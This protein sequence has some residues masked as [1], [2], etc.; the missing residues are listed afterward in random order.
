MI[1]DTNIY[2]NR[3]SCYACGI[4]VE[5]CIMDNL[6]LFLAPCR[7]ECPLHMNCQGYVR[8][9]AHGKEIEAAKEMRAYLPFGGILG[10]VCHHPCEAVCERIQLGDGALHIRALKRYLADTFPEV[11]YFVPEIGKPTDKQIAIIGSGPAGLMAAYELRVW[12]HEVV[13]YESE[14][15]PGGLL[16]WGIPSF[17]LPISETDKAIKMLVNMDIDFRTGEKI[18]EKVPFEDLERRFDSILVAVG[19]GLSAKLNI[20]GE[21]SKGVYKGLELLKEVKAGKRPRV[22]EVVIVI[23]GGNVAVDTALTCLKLGAT[24][25]KMVCLEDKDEMPAFQMELDEALEE[26]VTLQ[27][28]RGPKE[29]IYQD[30]KIKVVLEECICVFDDTGNFCPT[31]NPNNCDTL[32]ADTVIVAIGQTGAIQGMPSSLC[33]DNCF[34]VDPLSFQS[35]KKQMIFVCGDARTGTS[36]VVEAMAEG[37]EAAISIDRFLRGEGLKW[38]RN[39]WNG[40][41]LREYEVDRSCGKEFPR[42]KLVK[43]PIEKRTFD[44]EVEKGLN[45]ESAKKEAERCLSCGRAV[46]FN[47]TCWSCLPCEIECPVNALE[48]RMPY[49]IR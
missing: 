5:R 22:G 33:A 16:R 44:K 35:Y 38:G 26:G 43:L 34:D 24:D 29:F 31:M 13:V 21:D 46:E 20:Q 42:T 8:L 3:E 23:G 11:A 47:N 37:R 4:C 28:C 32:I 18:G 30:G 25:V 14:S 7:T 27:Y 45:P 36:S 2:V 40:P 10:R 48:V 17:R 19:S 12:G 6:R 9:I 15:E 49:L 41:N 1:S 39:F